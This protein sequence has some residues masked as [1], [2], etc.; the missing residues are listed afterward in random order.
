MQQRVTLQKTAGSM[1]GLPNTDY[2]KVKRQYHGMCDPSLR[3]STMQLSLLPIEK[4]WVW[5]WEQCYW[6]IAAVAL[7]QCPAIFVH[8]H[9]Q[10]NCWLKEKE[11]KVHVLVP[12]FTQKAS[13]FL[14][15]CKPRT[16][17]LF[18]HLLYFHF[19]GRWEMLWLVPT[20]HHLFGLQVHGV[21]GTARA[22]KNG[23]LE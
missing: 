11:Q 16:I 8:S 1:K 13:H 15:F 21:W 22:H 6:I 9:C 18:L 4:I 12:L 7:L 5:A 10:L 3:L 23:R 17:V 20:I 19:S 14:S 2:P